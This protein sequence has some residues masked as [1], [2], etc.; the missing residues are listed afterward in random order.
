MPIGEWVLETACSQAKQWHD[1]GI[2]N[3]GVAVN[4]S[5]RQFFQQNLVQMVEDVL[6]KTNLAPQYL[7]LEITESMT[8]DTSHTIESLHDLKR[9][10]VKIAVD[11]FGTGY[12]SMSYLKDFPI[13]CLKID[14]SFVQ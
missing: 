7:E 9:L 8:M 11:D 4:L 6:K 1:E 2:S 13:D 10:G 5:I 14:R 3:I 12:S